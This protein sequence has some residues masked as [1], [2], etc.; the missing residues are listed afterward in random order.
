MQ[1]DTT[2]QDIKQKLQELD[3]TIMNLSPEEEEKLIEDFKHKICSKIEIEESPISP[4][5]LLI[6]K[7]IFIE[8]LDDI[9]PNDDIKK[10][11]DNIIGDLHLS[12]KSSKRF[13]PPEADASILEE[14][15]KFEV[16]PI[17]DDDDPK[18]FFVSYHDQPRPKNLVMMGGGIKAVA[19]IGAVKFLE[20]YNLRKGVK[21]VI[22]TSAGSL[23]SLLFALGLDSATMIEYVT[24]GKVDFSKLK[25]IGDGKGGFIGYMEAIVGG[26]KGFF[27]D[28]GVCNGAKI[29]ALVSNFHLKLNRSKG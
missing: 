23:I 4:D 1:A 28:F 18:G 19:H 15:S 6:T 12:N 10:A 14:I 20:D 8:E 7:K 5:Y 9:I 25:D 2:D 17:E 27:E 11:I 29:E 16:I 26:F 24:G 3:H 13:I 22:G 21:K